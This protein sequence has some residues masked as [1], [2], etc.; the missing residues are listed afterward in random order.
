MKV[1]GVIILYLKNSRAI[2]LSISPMAKTAH[3]ISGN[4]SL[5][6]EDGEISI[7]DSG[8]FNSFL[9]FLYSESFVS[10]SFR[11]FFLCLLDT[12]FNKSLNNSNAVNKLSTLNAL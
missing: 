7:C 10:N 3:S 12:Y 9:I 5:T 8:G 2:S 6:H 1:F 4:Q 11:V